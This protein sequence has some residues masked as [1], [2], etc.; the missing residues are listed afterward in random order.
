MFIFTNNCN[1]YQTNQTIIIYFLIESDITDIKFYQC[2]LLN[3]FIILLILY[4]L[5]IL[6]ILI[7]IFIYF[8]IFYVKLI[9]FH[10]IQINNKDIG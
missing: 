1:A 5:Y 9:F 2:L 10:N 6:L 7:H 8:I 4:L 3:I